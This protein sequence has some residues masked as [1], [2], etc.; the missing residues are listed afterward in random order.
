MEQYFDNIYEYQMFRLEK[1]ITKVN[2]GN[3]VVK[4]IPTPLDYLQGKEDTDNMINKIKTLTNGTLASLFLHPSIE[5]EF[6]ELTKDANVYPSFKYEENSPLHRIIN[7]LN[8]SG[9]TIKNINSVN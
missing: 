4:Y 5:F 2:N 9:Y 1:N 7:T 6:I 8:K 3:R